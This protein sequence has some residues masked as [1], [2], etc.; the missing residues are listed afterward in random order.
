MKTKLTALLTILAVITIP[1]IMAA[2][3]PA[4]ER[5]SGRN[6]RS[7]SINVSGDQPIVSC[8][9]IQVTYERQPAITEESEMTL[10]ASQ[11]STLRAQMA[12]GGIYLSGWDRMEYSVKT[13]KA[14]PKDDPNASG[15]L[16]E[17]TTSNAGGQLSV[18]G[19]SGREWTANLI[20]MA[21]RLSTLALRTSNGPLQLRDLAGNIQLNATNGPISLNNVGGFVQAATVNGPISEKAS[22]GDHRLTANN[23]PIH[24]G[25]SGTRWDGPG[26]EASTQN[27]P[28]SISI[29]NGYD[30]GISIQTSD[31]SPVSCQAPVCAAATRSL[32]ARSV[33]RLGNGDPT[34][35]LSTMNGPLTIQAAKE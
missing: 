14:A 23:G 31:R 30:S 18:N 8:G 19:P 24:V 12:N 22:S 25:L 5:A 2:Q 1:W 33:I 7:T 35:R 10:P 9:D 26:L 11:V 21:P 16:R 15:T 13:C 17:I 20:I 29:P 32:S 3:T 28:L 27:G 4:Q 6:G 34:V